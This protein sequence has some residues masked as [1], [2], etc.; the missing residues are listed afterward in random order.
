MA[1]EPTGYKVTVNKWFKAHN[2][3]F[4]PAET[5]GQKKGFPVYRVPLS[6]YNG[7][8]DD[9]TPFADLCATAEPEYPRE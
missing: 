9:G 6:V 2:V 8:T 4:R 7:T 1:A 3:T 5:E